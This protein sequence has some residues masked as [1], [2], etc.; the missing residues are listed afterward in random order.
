[1]CLKSISKEDLVLVGG[2]F[3]FLK[4]KCLNFGVGS[5]I[6]AWFVPRTVL[7]GVLGP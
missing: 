4:K 5:C 7:G 3:G 2:K 6:K 1:M